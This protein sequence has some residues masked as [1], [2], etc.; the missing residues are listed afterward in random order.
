MRRKPELNLKLLS[1]I[2]A[3]VNPARIIARL[4]CSWCVERFLFPQR[5]PFQ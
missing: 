4:S 5:D 2:P 1:K 3:L